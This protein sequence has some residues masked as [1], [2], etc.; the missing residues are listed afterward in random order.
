[1]NLSKKIDII[2]IVLCF[3]VSGVAAGSEY[4]YLTGFS[5]TFFGIGIAM[6]IDYL[7]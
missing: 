2:S 4:G 5:V 7:G 1:M 6:A 3:L